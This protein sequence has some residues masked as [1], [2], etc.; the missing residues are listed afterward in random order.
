MAAFTLTRSAQGFLVVM[1]S[2]IVAH[3]DHAD[4]DTKTLDA[5][6]RTEK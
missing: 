6:Q 1:Q 4:L 5:G 2:L 3:A